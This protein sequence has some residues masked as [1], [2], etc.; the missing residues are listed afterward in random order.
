MQESHRVSILQLITLE[1]LRQEFTAWGASLKNIPKEQKIL[2]ISNQSFHI[3]Q[4]WMCQAKSLV[5]FQ[6][7]RVDQEC[8]EQATI[9]HRGH[10]NYRRQDLSLI[11]TILL[12]TMI[13][14]KA[15]KGL[16]T[17]QLF[18]PLKDLLFQITCKH[19]NLRK[20][21]TRLATMQ[22]MMTLSS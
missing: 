21:L 15:R 20:Q 8:M 19:P 9:L 1:R 11:I 12:S 13:K 2:F 16:I 17:C 7:S 18:P 14:T 6:C 3:H 10:P 22:M 4:Q 5:Q